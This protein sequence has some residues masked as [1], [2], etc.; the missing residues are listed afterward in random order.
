MFSVPFDRDS[1][2]INREGII[3]E[4]EGQ[5]Q[6]PNRVSLCGMGEFGYDHCFH[7]AFMFVKGSEQAISTRRCVCVQVP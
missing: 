3:S 1:A 4:I 6:A 7:L 2:F 5:L